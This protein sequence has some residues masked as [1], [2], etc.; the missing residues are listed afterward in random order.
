MRLC[1]QTHSVEKADHGHAAQPGL[2][3]IPA[4][5]AQR[6]QEERV[7]SSVFRSA[8]QATDSTLMGCT[9]NSAATMKLRPLNPVARFNTQNSKT[10]FRAWKRTLTS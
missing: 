9:A 10:T 5:R 4:I 8:I 1:Q 3:R 2:E 7:H 6:E